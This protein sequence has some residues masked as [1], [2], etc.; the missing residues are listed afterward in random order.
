MSFD[1]FVT[2]HLLKNLL[3]HHAVRPQRT[4]VTIKKTAWQEKR[5]SCT[6]LQFHTN[7]C[8]HPLHVSFFGPFKTYVGQNYPE[9]HERIC[10]QDPRKYR[11]SGQKDWDGTI[12]RYNEGVSSHITKQEFVKNGLYSTDTNGIWG[13]A[14][15]DSS[16]EFWLQTSE[17]IDLS[18]HHF[19]L[20]MK[21]KG[22][23]EV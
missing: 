17:E 22:P 13:N 9:Q 18:I 8:V 12:E 14:I 6:A 15:H 11:I 3:F 2:V 4:F 21:W 1:V 16:N 10:L 7:N 5:G 23:P 20:S 19:V